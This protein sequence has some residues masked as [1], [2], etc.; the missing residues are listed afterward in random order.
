MCFPLLERLLKRTFI[1]CSASGRYTPPMPHEPT[2]FLPT[3]AA[4]FALVLAMPAA[5]ADNDQERARAA[6]QAGKILPLKN[7]LERLER[8]QPG[9]VLEVELEQGNGRW[10]YEIRLLQSGGR[11]VKLHVDAESGEVLRRRERSRKTDPRP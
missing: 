2:R 1:G 11:L 6:V 4:A 10:T 7:V 8:D 3:L 5:R 9:Q